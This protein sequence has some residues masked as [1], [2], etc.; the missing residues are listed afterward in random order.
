MLVP[1]LVGLLVGLLGALFGAALL[2][3]LLGLGVGG[4]SGGLGWRRKTASAVSS[5]PMTTMMM[6]RPPT[7]M[8][9]LPPMAMTGQ[10]RMIGSKRQRKFKLAMVL[11]HQQHNGLQ[12]RCRPP[13][14][15]H[16]QLQ[17]KR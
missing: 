9:S 5:T 10:P 2:G 17:K 7:L 4:S 8:V 14:K 16:G 11:I 15:P 3:A 12:L 1:L 6:G 13:M